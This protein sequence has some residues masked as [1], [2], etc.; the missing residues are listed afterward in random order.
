MNPHE[1][2]DQIYA[3]RAPDQ[4][5]WYSPHLEASLA[6]IQRASD[7][8]TAAI[9]DVGGGESTLADDLLARGY[10]DITVLDISSKAIQTSRKRMGVD[11]ELVH[12]LAA[13]ITQV[14]LEPSRFDV[15]HDRAVFHFLTAAADRAAYV[16]QVTRAMK[17]GGH[18]I[19]GAFGPQGPTR[20]SG[21]DV[22]RY[23]ADALHHEFG[24]QFRLL[25]S[26]TQLH[27]TPFGTEQQFL[28][29]FCKLEVSSKPVAG[30]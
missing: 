8:P 20:C 2:W 16:R 25:E 14:E 11:A 7:S 9:I 1:H 19:V 15:W 30:G 18:V 22:V 26:S 13:D 24:R 29:C 5:S 23:D 21:L 28:Y 6:L 17:P 12:W 10:R 4:V 3:T 27:R